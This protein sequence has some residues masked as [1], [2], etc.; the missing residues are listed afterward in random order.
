MT[1]ED[2]RAIVRDLINRADADGRGL[3]DIIDDHAPALPA[4]KLAKQVAAQI[5]TFVGS[6]DELEFVD[7]YARWNEEEQTV[8]G[9]Y[10]VVT[11]TLVISTPFSIAKKGTDVVATATAHRR[12]DIS[13]VRVSGASYP[14]GSTEPWPAGVR[15][16]VAG[17][18]W[19]VDFPAQRLGGT[20]LGQLIPQLLS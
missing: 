18:G 1:N 12:A 3:A 10:E 15:V 11:P 16:T 20:E 8:F 5:A 6:T 14:L 19:E 4:D 9:K 13:E 7:F 17:Q 2:V